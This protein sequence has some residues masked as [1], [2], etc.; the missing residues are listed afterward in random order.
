[1]AVN[2][3]IKGT[4]Q[5]GAV[6]TLSGNPT[7]LRPEIESRIEQMETDA[8][9]T[10]TA[11]TKVGAVKK[12]GA[13]EGKTQEEWPLRYDG[14]A[15][16]ASAVGDTT[17]DVDDASFVIPGH[18]ILNPATGEQMRVTSVTNNELT[19]VRSIGATP[20]AAIA[21]GDRL[22][23]TSIA[24]EEGQDAV[25]AR[26]RMTDERTWYAQKIAHRMN[27]TDIMAFHAMYG[28]S[29]PDRIN[30]QG[31]REFKK[32]Q[33]RAILLNEPTKYLGPNSR[34]IYVTGGM[35]Y[36]S[37]LYNNINMGGSLTYK[38]L[39]WALG[40]IFRYG[41]SKSR[42]GLCS[43]RVWAEVSSLPEVMAQ[44]RRTQDDKTFGGEITTI[45]VPGGRIV[46]AVDDSLEGDYTDNEI[47]VVD[48]S[49][50]ELVEAEGY[51]TEQINTAGAY[52]K[53]WQI[54]RRIGLKCRMP[55]AWG[56]IY[57]VGPGAY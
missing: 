20:E 23:Y 13:P 7:R 29:E 51:T 45:V 6:S 12:V 27:V 53:D 11:L 37:S 19:V 35:R 24:T 32:M 41:D 15:T 25:Q 3:H 36:W 38:G 47:L 34:T 39:C 40:R 57:R 43:R 48:F 46:L 33:N 16:A 5:S 18:I 30:A 50:A 49:K 17:I 1:M 52:R 26:M 10:L 2:E 56:R 31:V 22:I 9:P 4:G 28:P 14:V 44:I 21:A 54:Y 42:V 55:I 8:A